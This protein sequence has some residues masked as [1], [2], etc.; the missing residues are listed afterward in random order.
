MHRILLTLSLVSLTCVPAY[1]QSKTVPARKDNNL[2]VAAYNIQFFGELDHD[3]DKLAEV[4]QHFDVCGI[5]EVKV[6][7]EVA[8]LAKKLKEKT[9]K[10]WGHIFGVRTHRPGGQYHEAYAFVWR[11]DRV[12]LGDGVMG[13]IWD[14]EENFRND[15]FVASFRRGNF[16]FVMALIHT[17]WTDDDEGTRE[18]EV[19]AAVDQIHWMKSF[20]DERDLIFAGDFNY[21]GTSAPLKQMAQEGN[22][23]QLDQ[24]S[25]STFKTDGSGFASSYDHIFVGKTGKTADQ[26]ENG[27]CDSLDVCNLVYGNNSPTNMRKARRELSDH[28]PVFAVFRTDDPDDD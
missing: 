3:L 5:I 27:A 8:R 4:I 20:I 21:S 13:N 19:S 25:K 10:A 11:R 28:L 18:G 24:N 12:E 22:L 6:E 14:R 9:G 1:G 23:T 15:P 7:S 2:I 17:R 16:D 26:L